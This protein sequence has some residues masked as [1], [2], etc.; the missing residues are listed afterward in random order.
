MKKM[1]RFLSA[2]FLL[3]IT[4]VSCEKLQEIESLKTNV[5][6]TDVDD[7]EPTY[8]R[9]DIEGGDYSVG[10]IDRLVSP[11]RVTIVTKDMCPFI[12]YYAVFWNGSIDITA[13]FQENWRA[14]SKLPEG[15]DDGRYGSGSAAKMV[16]V[17]ISV[18][19]IG[20]VFTLKANYTDH[21][22][23]SQATDI[24]MFTTL[25]VLAGSTLTIEAWSSSEY[26]GELIFD[27]NGSERKVRFS[28]F[29]YER[30]D[31]SMPNDADYMKIFIK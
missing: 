24:F 22:E 13:L 18:Q 6:T 31:F 26:G 8:F 19:R 11:K 15:A 30:L 10:I 20:Y 28:A 9:L 4:M 29:G 17:D 3:S 12:Y 16:K 5:T 1:N 2:L 7:S 27:V 23:N 14:G 21:N 25:N